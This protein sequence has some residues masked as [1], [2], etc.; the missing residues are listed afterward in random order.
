MYGQNRGDRTHLR[1]RPD[2]RRP[3]PGRRCVRPV[4]GTSV[5]VDPT[6]PEAADGVGEV[7]VRGSG[8]MMGYAEHPDDLA[9]GAMLTE[10]RTGDLGTIGDD[11]L[12]R[13]HG[14]RSGFVKVMGLRVD[15]ARVEEALTAAG[16][17][18]C[19]NGDEDGL[20]VAVQP[21]A[22]DSQ[23][24]LSSIAPA[25]SPPGPPGWD[26]PRST[27]LRWTCHA[28]PAAS[29]TDRCARGT[30]EEHPGCDHPG[31]EGRGW[32]PL[33]GHRRR[34]RDPS[35]PRTRRHRPAPHLRPT[36]RRRLSIS[37]VRPRCASKASSAR[38]AQLAPP[39]A[40]RT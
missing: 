36:R 26:R 1:P 25:T 10:L 16:L 17:T 32:R 9:L 39:P 30:G 3:A 15:V 14:R 34:D 31:D 7:L 29:S 18:A 40:G 6:V 27:P 11:G 33:A 8:V 20:T 12:L 2:R 19:V 38:S 35:R 13:L 5:R 24:P 37:H 22:R 23:P 4:A 28:C 21:G